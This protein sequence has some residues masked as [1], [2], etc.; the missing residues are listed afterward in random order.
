MSRPPGPINPRN[1]PPPGGA[2]SGANDSV[3]IGDKPAAEV[4]AGLLF[5]PLADGVAKILG[6]KLALKLP[7][8]V[9][10][11]GPA[12]AG[13]GSVAAGRFGL[14]NPS[15]VN[16]DHVVSSG[17]AIGVSNAVS[18]VEGNVAANGAAGPGFSLL[19]PGVDGSWV[20]AL[21]A[22]VPPRTRTP[23]AIAAVADCARVSRGLRWREVLR[24]AAGGVDVDIVDP[25]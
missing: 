20:S 13:R 6:A 10:P 3:A 15:T 23:A 16:A 12:A 1:A 21:R 11:A 22:A 8:T 17:S 19:W 9:P 25:P 2:A 14:I 24:W 7:N 5:R 4:L 18:I